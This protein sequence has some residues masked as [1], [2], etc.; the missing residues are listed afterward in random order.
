ML[1]VI[2]PP[3]LLTPTS[4]LT[5]IPSTAGISAQSSP[6]SS[7]PASRQAS[8]VPSGPLRAQ[9]NGPISAVS[10]LHLNPKKSTRIPDFAQLIF[11]PLEDESGYE[12]RILLLVEI[13]RKL[14]REGEVPDLVADGAIADQ[15]RAQVFHAFSADENINTLG[16]IMAFG[17]VSTYKE[18]D[19]QTFRTEVIYPNPDPSYVDHPP[20]APLADMHVTPPLPK[21]FQGVEKHF[22]E[23]FATLG[24]AASDNALDAIRKRMRQLNPWK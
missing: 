7:I 23:G 12:K 9:S 1:Q 6:L 18:F 11:K 5:S 17:D 19:R 24:T 20:G 13:K 8:G 16:V 10:T 4:A 15:I 2:P 3:T 22:T 21:I 14:S